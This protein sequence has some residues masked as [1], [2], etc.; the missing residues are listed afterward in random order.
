M[1]AGLRVHL[2]GISPKR[3]AILARIIQKEG[4]EIIND[5]RQAI[6]D[7]Q[8]LVVSEEP[9]HGLLVEP[10]GEGAKRRKRKPLDRSAYS[11]DWISQSMEQSKLLDKTSFAFKVTPPLKQLTLEEPSAILDP[12]FVNTTFECLRPCPLQSQNPVMVRMLR[13]QQETRFLEHDER[14]ATV[15]SR[16]AAA[17]QS[18]PRAISN[19]EELRAIKGIGPVISAFLQP[20]IGGGEPQLN[21]LGKRLTALKAFNGIHGVGPVQAISWWDRGI[22]SLAELRRAVEAKEVILRRD[23]EISLR[24]YSDFNTPVPREEAELILDRIRE[25]QPDASAELVGGFARG[26]ETGGDVDILIK[27][28]QVAGRMRRMLGKLRG[29]LEG[30]LYTSEPPNGLHLAFLAYRLDASRPCRR[31][32]LVFTDSIHYPF[33]KLGWLGSRQFERSLRRYASRERGI[34]L[35]SEGMRDIKTQKSIPA[36]SEEEI[37]QI[38]GVPYLP[39]HLRN[40]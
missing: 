18:Y 34:H 35:S 7:P 38:L 17:I 30:I 31:L 20:A 27:C 24:L 37:F 32:D 10:E 33:A 25:A 39:P 19:V 15:Y 13:H 3:A 6:E 2:T 28:D 5:A 9:V 8:V 21:P 12:S 1:F 4:G 40:C 14:G 36:A 29:H 26:K 22:H 23:Q 11:A 16:A